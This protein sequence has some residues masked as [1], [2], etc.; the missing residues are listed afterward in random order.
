MAPIRLWVGSHGDARELGLDTVE[1]LPE[2]RLDGAAKVDLLGHVA[3]LTGE[4][5]GRDFVFEDRLELPRHTREHEQLAPIAC[6]SRPIPQ[7][8]RESQ[9]GCHPDGVVEDGGSLRHL[10]HPAVGLVHVGTLD[11]TDAVQPIEAYLDVLGYR[12]V[13][14]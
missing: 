5:P 1:Q 8:K 13:Q 9:P 6:A 11:A 12:R 2:L 4:V 10:G 14:L 7:L 3:G